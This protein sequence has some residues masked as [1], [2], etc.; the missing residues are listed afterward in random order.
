MELVRL[1]EDCI[2][3]H[4]DA[5][6]LTEEFLVHG[7]YSGWGAEMQQEDGVPPSY[8]GQQGQDDG[9]DGWVD[10]AG[11][12]GDGWGECDMT[13]QEGVDEIRDRVSEL[14]EL[15]QELTEALQAN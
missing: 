1:C 2:S 9:G 13:L 8:A 14:E 11:N 3:E 15:I 5:E 10:N 4:P 7:S 6:E 12:E